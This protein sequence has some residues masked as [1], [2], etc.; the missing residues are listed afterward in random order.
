MADEI[1][2]RDANHRTVGA[3]VTADTDKDIVML[4]VDPVTKY[5]L[6]KIVNVGATSANAVQIADRDENHKTVCM[7]YDETNDVL[8]E[9][10]TDENG[11]LLCDL[12]VI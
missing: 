10:L 12:L 2:E 7:A 8:Q 11:Y 1:L 6:A 3:G 5:L 9:V 4:R